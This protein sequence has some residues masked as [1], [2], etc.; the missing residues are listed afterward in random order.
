MEQDELN[1]T[2]VDPVITVEAAPAYGHGAAGWA[3]PIDPEAEF[4]PACHHQIR[5]RDLHARARYLVAGSVAAVF[6]SNLVLFLG[7][8][9][10]FLMIV[11]GLLA[12]DRFAVLVGVLVVCGAGLQSIGNIA[13]MVTW[14]GMHRP[15]DTKM[16][17]ASLGYLMFLFGSI[18]FIV[19]E[20]SYGLVLLLVPSAVV[21]WTLWSYR[22]ALYDQRTC[23]IH[24]EFP[25]AVLAM[26][27]EDLTGEH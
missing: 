25:P 24:P 17:L 7:V 2:P 19:R 15:G 4:E 8:L 11:F 26:L 22:R 21:M 14:A 5:F 6:A 1:P 13:V 9:L 16:A 18:L 20:E 27:R 23:Q 10:G 12:A 3:A